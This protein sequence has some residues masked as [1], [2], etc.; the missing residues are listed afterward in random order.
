MSVPMESIL[1]FEQIE[2]VIFVNTF[3]G[4][5][6]TSQSVSLG[7]V[8]YIRHPSIGQATKIYDSWLF[9]T[10]RGEGL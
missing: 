10:V 9:T 2:H 4:V 8:I 3:S 5:L 7:D 1:R 6:R